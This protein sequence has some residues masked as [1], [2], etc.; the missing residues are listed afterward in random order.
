MNLLSAHPLRNSII[1]TSI[2]CY[3]NEYTTFTEQTRQNTQA[4]KKFKH[5]SPKRKGKKG[6]KIL[7]KNNIKTL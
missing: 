4:R 7:K 2:A 6:R 5:I 3:F 1:Y